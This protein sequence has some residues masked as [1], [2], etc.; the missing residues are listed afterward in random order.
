MKDL[1]VI[2]TH[3]CGLSQFT[4]DISA[5]DISYAEILLGIGKMDKGAC[6]LVQTLSSKR[7]EFKRLT[8]LAEKFKRDG[9]NVLGMSH[10]YETDKGFHKSLF[11]GTNYVDGSK[12]KQ[13]REDVLSVGHEDTQHIGKLVT[14][15]HTLYTWNERSEAL[16]TYSI[17]RSRDIGTHG[18][19][20]LIAQSI[21]D[22]NGEKFS[23]AVQR[24]LINAIPSSNP[25]VSM[26]RLA[27]V[28]SDFILSR[29][30]VIG[31]CLG[32]QSSI[33]KTF[34]G[35]KYTIHE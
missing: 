17:D 28:N 21:T 6:H 25:E 32:I 4:V 16:V 8:S 7:S 20:T 15:A 30:T 23:D 29:R 1:D 10:V 12:F 11:V 13:V 26:S 33:R 19:I 34:N 5:P 24:K 22:T 9:I 14:I 31:R 27:T 2:S 35:C 3:C 18:F